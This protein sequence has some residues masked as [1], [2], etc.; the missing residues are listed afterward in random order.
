MLSPNEFARVVV[1]FGTVATVS[2]PH[3]ITNVLGVEGINFMLESSLDIPLK[4]F[5]SIPSCVPAS[6]YDKNTN[7][8]SLTLSET[9]KLMQNKNLLYLG[10]FM[11]I[12]AILNDS[13]K[14]I[15]KINL[16]KK[17]HKLIDGHA[18]ELKGENLKKYVS[19]GISTDH[20]SITQ[21]EAIQ[22][23]N[24]GMY[25]QI[26][27]GSSAKN[28]DDLVSLINDYSDKC[29]FCSDDKNPYDLLKGHLNLLVKKAI[30]KNIDIFKVLKVATLNPIKHYKLNV[31]LLQK[32]DPADFI[33][34]DNLKNFE[35]LKTIINGKI[36]LK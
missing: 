23:I 13:P 8:K 34:V 3:E 22:K 12:D 5:F 26:R 6:V 24:L 21:E 28:F 31:G 11:D 2:D 33:I 30:A 4:I 29:M 16:A 36:V 17:Y 7:Y 20:E 1:K 15:K 35:I 9:K 19:A 14:A 10:E 25:V 18:P 27:E 32:N